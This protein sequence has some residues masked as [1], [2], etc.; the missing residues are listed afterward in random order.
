MT[1]AIIGSGISGLTAA[2][3][4]KD[5]HDIHVFEK[6]SYIGGHTN[7]IDL[8]LPDGDISVD[9]GFIVHNDRT[10]PNFIKL[11]EH[12]EVP[13]QNTEMSFSVKD[14][15]TG[16]E[17]NGGSLN[18]IFAQRSNLFR[19]SFHRM[20][21]EILRFNRTA[22]SFLDQTD[23]ELDLGGFLEKFA[24]NQLFIEKYLVPMGASIWSTVPGD[25]LKFPAYGFIRFFHHHGLLDLKDRPQW[26]TVTGG[27]REYVKKLTAD[28]NDRIHL[29]QGVQEIERQVNEVKLSFDD[30]SWK[31]FD[32]VII[33]CHS[34]EALRLLKHP[35][36]AEIEILGAIPYQENIAILHTDASVLPKRRLAWASWNYHLTSD[37]KA[38][39]ALTYHMN[40][41]QNLSTREKVNVTLNRRDLIDAS[42]IHKIITY[43]HPMFTR[44][45]L[46]AQLQKKRISGVNHTWYCGAYW[47]QGFH[48]DGV[49]SAFDVIKG[50]KGQP[51]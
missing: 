28:F 27:S 11:I 51:L 46:K 3:Y 21:F 10:Y 38:L 19:P 4:L 30:G 8:S 50:L 42:K 6:G 18:K 36:M 40:I 7:T 44:E 45:G 29:N 49:V 16:M 47:H 23:H 37:N 2:Y 39:A 17:Y 48:E 14:E 9:T 5:I 25:M 12:L 26:R 20:L 43:H 13:T 31:S 24:F 15:T 32:E 34:D 33:A 1:I 22:K 41:L 35:S